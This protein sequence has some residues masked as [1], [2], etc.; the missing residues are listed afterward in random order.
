MIWR[1]LSSVTIITVAAAAAAAAA[2][3]RRERSVF[4]S[5]VIGMKSQCLEQ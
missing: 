5:T 4:R 2:I 3:V 1:L